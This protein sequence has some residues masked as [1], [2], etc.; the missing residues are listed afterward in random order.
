M[1][2][3]PL[4]TAAALAEA[5]GGTLAPADAAMAVGSVSI[6]TRTL[7]PGALF[8][9]LAGGNADGHAHL[10]RARAAG[11]SAA[12]VR[13]D[14]TVPD[15]LAAIRV[16]DTMD[17][18]ARLGRAGRARFA[19]T[20]VAVTGSVGK[21]TTKEMLAAALGEVGAVHAAV[22]S[23]NNHWGVPLTLA[24]LPRDARFCVSEIGMNHPGE[25]AP[26]AA[27]VRPHAAIVT[28]IGTA[29]LGNMGDVDAIAREKAS[30]F[31]HL[32]PGGVA[33]Y[34]SDSPQVRILRDAIPAGMRAVGFGTGPEAQCCLLSVEST[35]SGLVAEAVL[36]G[37][38]LRFALASPG[39]HMAMNALAV[40]A[41]CASLGHD[42]QACARG[43]A[44]FAPG[45][46]R[47]LTRPILRGEA[48]LLDE[49]YNA[50]AASMRA[51]F[52]ILSILPARRRIAALG[53][54]LELGAFAEAEH[55]GLA[56]DLA[57]AADLV[58]ACGPQSRSMFDDLPPSR[59]G[60]W[61]EDSDALAALIA[62]A[63]RPGDAILV[64]GSNGSRMRRV[65]DALDAVGV[66]EALDAVGSVE[67]LDA[68][69]TG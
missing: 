1:T 56:A 34:P 11:A 9:A 37:R 48:L 5:V 38:P 19:G 15:G 66:V 4:W 31:A 58:F 53:D 57:R 60:A 29:H 17:G 23:Y 26:L 33:I 42:P 8:V 3:A 16:D 10:G 59:R 13:R 45:A 47:G 18:L 51:A 40:L 20:A 49:S 25:I 67:A 14:A 41:A 63:V 69:G 2:G 28:T 43:L 32:E 12:L 55:R 36:F 24:R 44:G 68:V 65:V 21:T 46:G 62:R 35:A 7:E 27:M 52:E 61:A 30:L 50:S 64:K 39:R 6:D 54:M 22:A